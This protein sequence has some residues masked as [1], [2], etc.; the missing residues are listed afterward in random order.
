VPNIQRSCFA[1]SVRHGCPYNGTCWLDCARNECIYMVYAVLVSWYLAFVQRIIRSYCKIAKKKKRGHFA[2]K[3]Y[4][5][6]LCHSQ[7]HSAR[8]RFP[9]SIWAGISC[10]NQFIE[11][12]NRICRTLFIN[13]TNRLYCI[14]V[15][16]SFSQFLMIW[17]KITGNSYKNFW[18]NRWSNNNGNSALF[19]ARSWILPKPLKNIWHLK[20]SSFPAKSRERNRDEQR[21]EEQSSGSSKVSNVEWK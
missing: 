12:K 20:F 21:Q 6:Q 17:Q 11:Q 5:L 3:I 4:P 13:L 19:E 18:K 15:H 7:L 8:N 16:S 2:L 10:T 9:C 1:I 14:K